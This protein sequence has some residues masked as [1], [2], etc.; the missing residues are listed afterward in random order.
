MG[1]SGPMLL[2]HTA[3]A[4]MRGEPGVRI[5]LEYTQQGPVRRVGLTRQEC[6]PVELW[7]RPRE[8]RQCVI[9]ARWD[10]AWSVAFAIDAKDGDQLAMLRGQFTPAE[11]A[12][13]VKLL[14]EFYGWAFV[15][16]EF[17]NPEFRNAFM[18]RYPVELIY[19]G[20]RNPGE[21]L[22]PGGDLGFETTDATRPRLVT[23][24]ADAIRGLGRSISIRSELALAECRA[25]TIGPDGKPGAGEGFHDGCVWAAALTAFGL[26]AAPRPK[27]PYGVGQLKPWGMPERRRKHRPDYDD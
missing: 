8:G 12:D 14:A 5:R 15:V 17:S 22:L 11:F 16:P 4:R 26:D 6:G 3:L 13:Q 24:L 9:G 7:S 1:N 20:R 27:N 25:F 23:A 18:K 21:P 2:D 10:P 19:G